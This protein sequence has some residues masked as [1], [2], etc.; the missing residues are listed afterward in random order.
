MKDCF[1]YILTN[2]TRSTLY[3]GVTSGLER[4]VWQHQN[5]IHP[6]FTE[7]YNCDR[8]VYY[9]AYPDT[10]QAIA[11]E[12]QLKKWR[13]DKKENLINT[14]NPTWR[15]LTDELFAQRPARIDAP[16][17]VRDSSTSLRRLAPTP[18]RSE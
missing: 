5:K 1:V 13:R 2:Q 7:K 8:L 10:Q 15:D 9:E 11:R 16:G 14:L 12:S 18:L 3:I 17:S 6:G 4:R